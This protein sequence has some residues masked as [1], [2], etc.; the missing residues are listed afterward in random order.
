MTAD[1]ERP[2][3]L[4]IG[5]GGT[6]GHTLPAIAVLAELRRLTAVEPLWIGSRSGVERRLTAREGIA[7]HWVPTGKLRREFTPRTLL[8]LSAIPIGTLAA[9]AVIR[10]FQPDVVFGTGG[11][12]SVPVVLAGWLNRIPIVIH[13][14]TA[15]VGLATRIAARFADAVA[16]SFEATR[17]LLTHPHL[18]HTGLPVREAILRGDP[19]RARRRFGLENQAPLLYVTGGVL[20]AHAINEAVA[21]ALPELLGVVQVV[22]Q[23]GPRQVNGD[24]PR[25]LERRASLPEALRRRYVVVEFLE[26]DLPDVLAAA[27]LVLGRAGASTVAELAALGKPA[28]LV[29]LPGARGNEQLRNAQLLAQAGSAVILDQRELS[30][31]QLVVLVRELVADPIALARMGQ[32]GRTLAV[33]D[34]AER[35]ARLILAVARSHLVEP[36]PPAPRVH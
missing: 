13:E 27:D 8:D 19:D 1:R 22:H 9:A 14:Q 4:V 29:P 36:A 33:P 20:G 28:I 7:F 18:V 21:R 35:L 31:E 30:P 16:I 10:S 12:V 26:E 6:G 34:A 24:F 11:Y 32:R 3:R 5:G 25:L 15:A 2:L 17:A 23:C